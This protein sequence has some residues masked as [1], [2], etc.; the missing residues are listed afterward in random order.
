MEAT[1]LILNSG[2]GSKV[3]DNCANQPTD[4]LKVSLHLTYNSGEPFKLLVPTPYNLLGLISCVF[5]TFCGSPVFE[6]LVLKSNV[7]ASSN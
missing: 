4:P 7:Y 1:H 5:V 3:P 2:K 6:H